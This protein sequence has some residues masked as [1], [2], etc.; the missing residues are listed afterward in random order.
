[1]S[2]TIYDVS[3]PKCP[4][5]QVLDRVASKWTMLV[6][7]ALSEER[8]RYSQLR[9]RLPAITQKVLTQTLR[10]L[11]RDGVVRRAVYDSVPPKTEYD[12]TPLGYSLAG[13]VAV[14]RSWAYNNM[15]DIAAAR[16]S[17][18]RHARSS[19]LG[20]PSGSAESN[21]TDRRSRSS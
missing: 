6:I 3:N 20:A 7:L 8:L 18:D 13:A 12:L 11:E 19:R 10:A 16:A 15:E 4:T 9:G 17:Y 21:T 2:N 14:V 5:Q 1:M